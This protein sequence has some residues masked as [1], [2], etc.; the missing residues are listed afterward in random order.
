MGADGQ[1]TFGDTIMKHSAKKIRTLSKGKVLA[2]FAGSVADAFA[3]FEKFESKLEQYPSNLTR[4]S[5]ELG[6]EW[7]TDKYLR[8]LEALL[9]VGN[10]DNMFLLSGK[11]DV[12]EPDE[13]VIAIGS[14]GNYAFSAAKALM[15]FSD[16]SARQIVE[17]SL[18][19]AADICIY[20]NAK[21]IVEELAKE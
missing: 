3:L 12:I 9:I 16:L 6:K 17:E 13:G 7:R 1:V 2:G 20:T 15:R 11:G 14:G 18:K 10:K 21:I 5:V 8:N 4:A 19:I